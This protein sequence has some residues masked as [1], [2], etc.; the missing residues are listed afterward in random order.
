MSFTCLGLLVAP[1]GAAGGPFGAAGGPLGP[2]VAPRGLLVAPWGRW[3][4]VGVCWW[5]LGCKAESLHQRLMYK[6]TQGL[7]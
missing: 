2:L 1:S 6:L 3:R 4:P 7:R 5:S